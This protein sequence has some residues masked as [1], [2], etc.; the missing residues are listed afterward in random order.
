MDLGNILRFVVQAELVN[1]ITDID[2][3]PQAGTGDY[4]GKKQA[5]RW[6]EGKTHRQEKPGSRLGQWDGGGEH[7][8]YLS[9]EVVFGFM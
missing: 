5:D 9:L 8:E 4:E 2:V 6:Q 3:R 1:T 7:R